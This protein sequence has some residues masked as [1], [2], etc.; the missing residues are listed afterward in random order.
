MRSLEQ[1]SYL[2]PLGEHLAGGPLVRSFGNASGGAE[3]RGA[4]AF[5]N[6][7]QEVP[8]W[9]PDRS[10]PVPEWD[11]AAPLTPIRD[12]DLQEMKDL[13]EREDMRAVEGEVDRMLSMLFPAPL[14]DESSW[15]TMG[16]LSDF[17]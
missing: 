8:S 16:E 10:F 5:L 1:V 4:V 9:V 7:W 12:R 11:H 6:P 3:P 14:W 13:F 17:L 2:V 15:A